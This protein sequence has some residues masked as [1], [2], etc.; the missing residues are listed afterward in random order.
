MTANG[1][2]T[3]GG[4]LE[5]APTGTATAAA[6]DNS[7]MLKFYTS[8]YNSTSKAVL[9]P[10]FEWQAEVTGNNTASPSATLNLLSSTTSAGATETGFP[11]NPNGTVNFAKGQTFPGTGRHHHCSHR[12]YR[13]HR[14]W[15]LRQCHPQDR[16]H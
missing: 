16:P 14:R 5:L 11:F 1:G 9:N 13:P 6:G 10:R 4:S 12:R 2:A 3:V 15:N 7:Q 8:A